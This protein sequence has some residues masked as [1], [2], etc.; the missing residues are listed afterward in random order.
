M[1]F[2][3]H[4]CGWHDPARTHA[5][6]FGCDGG[7]A[8]DRLL[9]HVVEVAL[10]GVAVCP[11]RTECRALLYCPQPE[12]SVRFSSFAQAPFIS[13]STRNPSPSFLIEPFVRPL[14]LA[15]SPRSAM[16]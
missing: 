10:G 8:L 1:V 13:A 16:S 15:G 12:S 9:R 2:A 6:A 5:P 11:L 3:G 14:D 7:S 4:S